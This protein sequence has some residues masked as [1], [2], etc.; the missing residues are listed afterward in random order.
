[1]ELCND[2]SLRKVYFNY[3][4]SEPE[5]PYRQHLSTGLKSDSG[6]EKNGAFQ[7]FFVEKNGASQRKKHVTSFKIKN[8]PKMKVFD[9][10]AFQIKMHMTSREKYILRMLVRAFHITPRNIFNSMKSSNI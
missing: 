5:L 3:S 2:S 4:A 7:I 6:N 9:F 10:G 1:M 8:E